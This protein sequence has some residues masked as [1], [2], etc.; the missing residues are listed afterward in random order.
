MESIDICDKKT[1]YSPCHESQGWQYDVRHDTEE[2]AV[3]MKTKRGKGGQDELIYVVEKT[4]THHTI[5]LGPR[6]CASR[7]GLVV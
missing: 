5:R 3:V 2:G 6:Y 7:A 1:R 4:C